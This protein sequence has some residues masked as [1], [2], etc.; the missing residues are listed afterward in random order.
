[1]TCGVLS[2]V[3]SSLPHGGLLGVLGIKKAGTPALVSLPICWLCGSQHHPHSSLPSLGLGAS[4]L[5]L[6]PGALL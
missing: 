4:S 2:G 1:M 3:H 5:G 6:V